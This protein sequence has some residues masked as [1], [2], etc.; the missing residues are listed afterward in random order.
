MIYVQLNEENRIVAYA[1]FGQDPGDVW[2]ESPWDAVP[3]DF[4]DWL[5]VD[6]Q[7]VHDPRDL[8][9]TPYGA[10]QVLAA[11]MQETDALDAL[12]DTALAHM[13]P[14]MA[15]WGSGVSYSAGDKVQYGE[16]PYRCLQS[17]GSQD[18][19]TPEDAPSLWA[20]ILVPSPD[21]IPDWEQPSSTNPY[22]RGD[23]VRHVGKVWESL[24]DNNVWEPGVP[25]T[26]ALWADRQEDA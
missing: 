23:K 9:P 17:H 20:R 8:P 6:G 18:A 7:L 2:V 15:E 3:E 12:P 16:R 11:I 25:G 24:V 26:E 22:M 19:W 21:I 14:Y 10:E 5:L 13:A 4:A 1:D